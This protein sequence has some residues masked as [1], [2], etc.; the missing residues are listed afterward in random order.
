MPIKANAKKALR[1]TI[2]RAQRNT[3]VK[4]EIHSL[5]VKLRKLLDSKKAEE[6]EKLSSTIVKK[7]DKAVSKKIYKQNTAARLKSRFM[8]KINAAKK[9]V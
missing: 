4:A 2:K 5:R 1:Q 6:A 9:A 3:I 7:L 8:Q